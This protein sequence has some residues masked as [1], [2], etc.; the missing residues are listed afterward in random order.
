MEGGLGG[1][2]PGGENVVTYISDFEMFALFR[3]PGFRVRVCDT[4]MKN[5]FSPRSR[6]PIKVQVIYTLRKHR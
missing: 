5:G 2:R 6:M 1:H 4:R 3:H